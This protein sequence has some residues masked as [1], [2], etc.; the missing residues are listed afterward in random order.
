MQCMPR[1]FHAISEYFA[2]DVEPPV[3]VIGTLTVTLLSLTDTSVLPAVTP[4]T[5]TTLLL[6][7]TVAT[8]VLADVGRHRAGVAAGRELARRAGRERQRGRATRSWP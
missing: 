7:E 3:T 8:P 1:S 5:V 6:T 4:L 2:V